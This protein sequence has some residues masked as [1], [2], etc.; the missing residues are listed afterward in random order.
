LWGRGSWRWWV[1]AGCAKS[2]QGKG[3]QGVD[4][5]Y[6]PHKAR[7]EMREVSVLGA[8]EVP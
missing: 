5:S 4:S 7:A 8:G 1:G 6:A 3:V 2:K